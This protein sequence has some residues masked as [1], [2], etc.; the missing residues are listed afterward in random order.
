MIRQA[1]LDPTGRY[2]YFLARD[3]GNGPRVAFVMLNPSTADAEKDDATIRRCVGFAKLWGFASLGV[4]NL[5]GFRCTS[6][7]R[8][9]LT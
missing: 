9:D 4:V 7:S 2:R 5:Y 6:P 3:W 1:V 8:L